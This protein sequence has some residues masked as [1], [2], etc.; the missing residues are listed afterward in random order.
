ICGRLLETVLQSDQE[1]R[2]TCIHPGVG[3]MQ[4]Q[5][6]YR[7]FDACWPVNGDLLHDLPPL[8]FK[9]AM[10]F[11]LVIGCSRIRTPQ[12]L[13]MAFEIAPVPSPMLVTPT[14]LVAQN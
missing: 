14:L 12:A 2:T 7:F 9:P 1:V 3:S 10:I 13:S 4:R 11:S 8:S 6:L 5:D